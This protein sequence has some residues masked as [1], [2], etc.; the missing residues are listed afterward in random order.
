MLLAEVAWVLLRASSGGVE[1]G[2]WVLG[3][4]F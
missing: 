2:R 1:G 4:A 3:V